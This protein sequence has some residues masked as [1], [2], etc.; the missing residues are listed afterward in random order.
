MV[1]QPFRK[2]EEK[3]L[4]ILERFFEQ[5]DSNI[6]QIHFKVLHEYLDYSCLI[7]EVIH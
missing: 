4:L 5:M 1:Q 3:F 2:D 6:V 7:M